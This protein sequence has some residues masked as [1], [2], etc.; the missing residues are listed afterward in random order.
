MLSISVCWFSFLMWFKFGAYACGEGRKW[1]GD[2]Q[3][4]NSTW[5][6]DTRHMAVAGV[7]G[8]DAQ[9][10]EHPVL[11]VSTFQV[12]RHWVL[13]FSDYGSLWRKPTRKRPLL[14]GRTGWTPSA[15]LGFLKPHVSARGQLGAQG[16]QVEG[17]IRENDGFLLLTSQFS[18]RFSR[19]QEVERKLFGNVLEV[20]SWQQ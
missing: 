6:R 10:N 4:G 13:Y 7:R 2:K 9:R 20:S 1:V 18:A 12:L 5:D 16:E 14:G 15:V 8:G 3:T 11:C 17:P 19:C